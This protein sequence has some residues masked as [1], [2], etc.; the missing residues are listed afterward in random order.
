MKESWLVLPDYHVPFHNAVIHKKIC[1]LIKEFKP[2]GIVIL[3][4][5]LDM[6]SLAIW[7]NGSLGKLDGW[8][9]S[10]E[11]KDG[12]AVLAELEAVLPSGSKRH[13]IYGNHEDRYRRWLEAGD[14]AKVGK[15]LIS[16]EDALGLREK[17]YVV[18]TNWKDDAVTLGEHLDVIHG[19]YCVQHP[20]K[21]HLEVF[22][23][24]VMFGHTHRFDA[25]VIGK[26][27]AYNIGFLGDKKSHGFDY[28]PRV[29]RMNWVNGFAIVHIDDKGDYFA[30][31]ISCV[32]NKFIANGKVY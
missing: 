15:E 4:D 7:N 3:G 8:T 20:A 22:Q 9:L 23:R 31:P 30:Q 14:N 1:K 12:K 19:Q 27:G 29:D 16:P 26:R 28:R 2:Y 6:Y 5:F 25:V 21:K 10:K 32:G 11:Y 13:F 24:S 18:H 17:K